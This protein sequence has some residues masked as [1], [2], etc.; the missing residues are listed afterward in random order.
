VKRLRVAFDVEKRGKDGLLYTR[1]WV[2]I[3]ARRSEDLYNDSLQYCNPICMFV[4]L[5]LWGYS[6]FPM[7][8]VLLRSAV[9]V[10]FNREFVMRFVISSPTCSG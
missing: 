3:S 4:W 9:D 8:V 10:V 7:H 5:S 6:N 1:P 2:V